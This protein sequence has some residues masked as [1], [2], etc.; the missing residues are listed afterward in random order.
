MVLANI[1]HSQNIL[2]MAK[3]VQ[4]AILQEKCQQLALLK[5]Y[6]KFLQGLYK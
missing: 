4:T 5:I 2:I 6:K 3:V 1:V